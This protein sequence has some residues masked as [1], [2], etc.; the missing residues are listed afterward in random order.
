MT[1]KNIDLLGA[2]YADVPAVHLPETGGGT[3]EFV[4]I[5]D[6]TATAEDVA[7][8]KYFYSAAGVK[9]EGTAQGGTAELKMGVLRPDAEIVQS[10]SYDKYIVADEGIT[11]PAYTTTSQTLK[12]SANLTPTVSMDLTNYNYYV[13]ERLLTIPS[14]SVTTKAKGRVEYWLNS[15]LYEITEYPANTFHALLE[16]TRKLASRTTTIYAAGA[17]PRLVYYTSGTAITAYASAAYGTAQTVTTPTISST[18]LTLKS[19]A[20]IVRGHTTYFANTYM[21][22]LTDIRNQYVIDVYRAPKN[23]LN[24]D[25]WGIYQGAMHILDCIDNGGELT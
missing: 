14:Y 6:T 16:P 21:N 4:E 8:G 5:S 7:S 12:A 19:P 22:A 20:F 17:G 2:Q 9:T 15:A 24:L 10:Y 13:F 23:N 3:A 25:G 11:I 18:T 1:V